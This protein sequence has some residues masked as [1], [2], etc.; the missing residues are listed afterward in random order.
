[1]KDNFLGIKDVY[2]QE[3]GFYYL[4]SRY[5]DPTVGRFINA[6]R[7]FALTGVFSTNLFTYCFN[8]PMAY[9]DNE[10]N[11]PKWFERVAT[12]ASVVI[13]V[14]AVAATVAA[15]TAFTGGTG[16][17]AAVYGASIF[18]G[19]A[20]SMLVVQVRVLHKQLLAKRHLVQLLEVLLV[21][22]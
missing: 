20:L 9:A 3:T 17:A 4:Q 8:N 16:S 2:D 12:V 13:T 19:A 5:Y 6:D 10:G 7:K 14:A 15:V 1:M 18:L 21:L 22:V 11:W